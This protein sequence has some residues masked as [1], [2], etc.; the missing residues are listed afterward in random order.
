V[1]R[2]GDL[3]AGFVV[4]AVAEVRSIAAAALSPAPELGG[5]DTRVFDRVAALD[6]DARMI[7]IVSPQE[8][9][10]RAERDLLSAIS[11]KTPARAS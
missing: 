10:D 5:G 4:D 9:L 3:S 1:V 2:L 6:G 11:G 7:L 8:L